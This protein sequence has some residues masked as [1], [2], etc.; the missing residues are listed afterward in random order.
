M[1]FSEY[2][3]ELADGSK[4]L[5]MTKLQRLSNLDSAQ[6]EELGRRWTTIDVRRRRRI[7]Q[8]LVDLAEDNADLDFDAVFLSGLQ[9][10]DPDVRLESLRGLWE[11]D[12]P[13]LIDSLIALME[14][15]K[16]PAVR[17]EAALALGRFVLLAELG[18]LR[19]RHFGR[20]EAALRRVIEN[21]KESDDVRGRAIESIGAYDSAWVRQ[22]IQNAYESGED[23]LK[24]SSVHAMGRSAESRWLPLLVH[25]LSNDDAE[26]RFEA[27][28]AIGQVAEESAI[29]HL[30]PLLTD[31][32]EEVRSAAVAALGEIGGERAK[33]ALMEMLDSASSAT[34]EAAAAA[35]SEIEFEED[36]LGFRFRK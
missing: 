36:P 27:A 9:D 26:I 25:E 5:A 33:S 7:L 11:A 14:N 34:R 31:E 12:S 29:P 24:V 22:A 35:L 23:S 15:E 16:N 8:E 2:L 4:R 6:R 1:D 13:D 10:N 30:V 18:R 3:D 20:V 21:V 19:E 17:A 28:V 32:D